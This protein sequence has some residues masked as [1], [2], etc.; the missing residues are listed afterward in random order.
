MQLLSEKAEGPEAPIRMCRWKSTPEER[1]MPRTPESKEGGFAVFFGWLE[2]KFD[3]GNSGQSESPA[4]MKTLEQLTAKP[5][6]AGETARLG[7]VSALQLAQNSAGSVPP[8]VIGER[9]G[10]SEDIWPVRMSPP[11]PRWGEEESKGRASIKRLLIGRKL[12]SWS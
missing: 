8:S 9:K 2:E 4:L 1:K 5:R 12:W 11:S 6:L 3:N 10:A 7:S